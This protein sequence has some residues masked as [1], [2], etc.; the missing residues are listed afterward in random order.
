[1]VYA[2]LG[3]ARTVRF[4]AAAGLWGFGNANP[5]HFWHHAGVDGTVWLSDTGLLSTSLTNGQFVGTRLFFASGTSWSPGAL[6][7]E[8]CS[9]TFAQPGFEVAVGGDVVVKNGTLGM[10][11]PF[12]AGYSELVCAGNLTLTNSGKLAIF[13]GTT[14]GVADFG[15]LVSVTGALNV[16]SGCWIYLSS[17]QTNGGS[18][19]FRVGDLML[20]ANGGFNANARGFGMGYGPGKGLTDGGRGSGGGAGGKGGSSLSNTRAGGSAFGMALAPRDAGSGGGSG[21]YTYYGGPGG[22]LVRAEVNGNIVV[23]FWLVPGTSPW[24]VKAYCVPMAD[25]R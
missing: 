20:A 11:D 18:G 17:H 5:E 10:G 15:A 4:S 21:T 23:S 24:E 14:N 25:G 13:S 8:N 2:G 3:A 16:A 12:G 7:I 6:T 22:G 1:M 9:L 19:L